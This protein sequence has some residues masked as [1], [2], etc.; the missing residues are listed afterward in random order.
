M[1]HITGLRTY[2]VAIRD[3]AERWIER[4]ELSAQERNPDDGGFVC[5][6]TGLWLALAAVASGARGRTADELAALL[7]VAAAP[8]ATAA[9]D[10]AAELAATD[11][12]ATATHVWSTVPL[13][14]DFRAGLPDI[15]FSTTI[16]PAQ[17]NAWVREATDGIIERLPVPLDPSIVLAL[18]NALVLQARWATPFNAARTL[19]R[20]FRDALGG[21]HT[22]PTM[23]RELRRDEAWMFEGSYVV[24]LACAP[25]HGGRPARVRLVLGAEGR[26]AAEVLPAAWA[27]RAGAAPIAADQLVVALPRF[28]LRTTHDV[29]GELAA[30]GV[31]EATSAT[32]D[33]SALSPEPLMISQVV[34]EAVVEAAELGVRAAAVTAV[35][36][37]RG[38]ARPPART[39]VTIAFD[40]PFGIAVMDG[41]GEVPLF[42]GWQSGAP[43]GPE[44]PLSDAP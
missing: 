1:A 23:H 14:E 3:L 10:A 24:E 9:T 35:L 28:A 26:S 43:K 27:P 17:I 30:L 2:G 19:P 34:Q 11:S 18:V 13:H 36:M 32:A 42:A 12:L 7:G 6:P 38:A 22:V 37:A 33:F 15:G 44:E 41:S 5:S 21:L 39:T 25:V 29:T 20:P 31:H 8:A 4:I 16:D 40:R